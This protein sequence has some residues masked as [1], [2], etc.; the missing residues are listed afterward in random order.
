MSHACASGDAKRTLCMAGRPRA[1]LFAEHE[2]LSTSRLPVC[3]Q[4]PATQ[5]DNWC[6]PAI[7]WCAPVALTPQHN[8]PSGC[9]PA[10]AQGIGLGV[11][12]QLQRTVMLAGQA[13]LPTASAEASALVAASGDGARG[14][15]LGRRSGGRA[16]DAQGQPTLRF[17]A[18]GSRLTGGGGAPGSGCGRAGRD[19]PRS[20]LAVSMV[21]L[22]VLAA[23][24]AVVSYAAQYRMVLAS[25]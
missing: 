14:V 1:G 18:P 10:E 8:G 2:S 13:W 16:Q 12:M 22:A 7:Y 19:G 23:A 9:Q 11:A 5:L 15:S 4:P 17:A 21:S 25:K 3:W 20:W 24:A 6:A